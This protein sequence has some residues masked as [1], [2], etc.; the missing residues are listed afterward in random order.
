[1]NYIKISHDDMLNG[2]G[3]RVVLWLSGCE[4]HCDSCHNP[5]TWNFNNGIPFGQTELNYIYNE[6]S[7]DYISGITF[8]GG[9]PFYP[10][11]RIEV[12]RITSEIKKYFPNKNI[13]VYTG[14]LFEE[15]LE[16]NLDISNIDVIVDGEF[17]KDLFSPKVPWIG[18]SNQRIID[19]QKSLKENKIILY[20]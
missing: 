17:I 15:V 5:E 9:D 11:N 16:W 14:Y 3:L 20:N 7:H 10:K 19:V 2:P 13:W 12:I 4:H 1:M 18:S 6:L 8:S